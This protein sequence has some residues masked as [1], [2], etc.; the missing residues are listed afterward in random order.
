[1]IR[2][3][4]REQR[5]L[6]F[7]GGLAILTAWVYAV[8]IIG[9]LRRETSQLGRQ[10]REAREQL[11]ILEVAVSSEAA[12]EEKSRRLRE[13]VRTLR[14]SLTPEAE[15]PSV[16]ELLTELASQTQVKVQTIF[17]QRPAEPMEPTAPDAG[18]GS[19]PTSLP[20]VYYKEVPIQI[21]ALAGYHQLG[22]FLNL[23]E[24]ADKPMRLLSLRISANPKEP[25]WHRVK[26]LV[27][28]YV[29]VPEAAPV[30]ALP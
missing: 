3:S 14:G 15:L 12:L 10:I 16:I 4:K 30:G 27:Q 22:T 11:R 24:T 18:Q 28:S 6:V 19:L 8:Y 21:D 20:A 25:R 5:L 17:P 23:V 2:M 7:V 1:M 9:P 29:A 26:L 13:S